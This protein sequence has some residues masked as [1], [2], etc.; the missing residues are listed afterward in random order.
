M[1]VEK[2][3]MGVCV[4][5]RERR[6]LQPA[7]VPALGGRVGVVCGNELARLQQLDRVVCCAPHSAVRAAHT[8]RTAG[9]A[10]IASVEPRKNGLIAMVTTQ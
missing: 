1:V 6:M 3:E 4:S 8:G 5:G 10:A 9:W 2:R 7:S